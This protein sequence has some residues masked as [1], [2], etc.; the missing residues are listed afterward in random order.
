MVSLCVCVYVYGKPLYMCVRVCAYV[1]V[2]ALVFCPTYVYSSKIYD[3]LG[4]S[5]KKKSVFD[6]DYAIDMQVCK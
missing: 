1:C 5:R 2:C 6:I 4:L 3:N